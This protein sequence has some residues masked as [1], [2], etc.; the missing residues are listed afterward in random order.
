VT[1]TTV[2]DA[3]FGAA[4]VAVGVLVAALAD[5]IRGL[6]RMHTEDV[7]GARA[8]TAR[9]ISPRPPRVVEAAP[10]IEVVEAELVEPAAP[11]PRAQRV[12]QRTDGE[13]DVIDALVA[14]GYKKSIAAEAARGCASADRATIERWTAAALRRC[15]RGG[16]S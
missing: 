5:R 2:L 3:L 4:L 1:G 14:A 8:A 15:A 16:L 6:R 7:R 13:S 12:E 9:D 10:K 11:R